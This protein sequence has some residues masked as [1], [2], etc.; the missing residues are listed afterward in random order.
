MVPASIMI[1]IILAA[2]AVDSAG[3]YL[4]HQEVRNLADGVAN[5]AA[6]IALDLDA[7]YLDSETIEIDPVRAAEVVEASVAQWQADA[8]K[9]TEV[10][11]FSVVVDGDAIE[12]SITAITDPVFAPA[13]P[14][15]NDG[16]Q[17]TAV[18]RA[19]AVAQ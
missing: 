9:S 6:T 17:I 1:L 11:S 12:V 8:G 4:A 19:Q 15:G 5:D 16:V 10:T 18:G 7:Y 14:G 2:I 13:V 3:L